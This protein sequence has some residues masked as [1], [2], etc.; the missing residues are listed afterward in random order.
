MGL[1][2]AL[3]RLHQVRFRLGAAELNVGRGT[4]KYTWVELSLARTRVVL[5]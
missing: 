1:D 2:V 3:G 5:R 4:L